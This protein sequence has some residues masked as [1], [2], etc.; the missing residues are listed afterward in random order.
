MRITKRLVTF[1]I[2][3]AIVVTP[4]VFVMAQSTYW[5][6]FVGSSHNVGC[7]GGTLTKSATG[8]LQLTLNTAST[9]APN[10]IF[11][12]TVKIYLFSEAAT[13]T[14]EVIFNNNIASGRVRLESNNALFNI[15][16]PL[17]PDVYY[18]PALD[19]QGSYLANDLNFTLKA[20]A[21]GG[22]YTLKFDAIEGNRN[23]TSTN[24]QLWAEGAVSITVAS[25]NPPVAPDNP[26]VDLTYIIGIAL[27]GIVAVI[28][29]V[30]VKV[31]PKKKHW[32]YN[33]EHQ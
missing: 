3:L 21:T 15:L 30:V 9:M 11:N 24:P 23:T 10:A 32:S 13:Y 22:S 28:A 2:T 33:R 6:R 14:P 8:Y 5:D 4:I 12:V 25:D 20:P 31:K 27:A 19:S 18:K 17:A 26:P 29:I 7:H 16:Y 1:I